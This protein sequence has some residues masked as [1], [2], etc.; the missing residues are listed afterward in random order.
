MGAAKRARLT[1]KK[2]NERRR[3]GRK[4]K[5]PR[6]RVRIVYDDVW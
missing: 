2:R 3:G 4:R 1:M 5:R 6:R